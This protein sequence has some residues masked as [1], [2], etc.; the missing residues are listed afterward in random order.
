MPGL[1]YFTEFPDN[2]KYTTLYLTQSDFSVPE[3]V[4]LSIRQRLR[5]MPPLKPLDH[6]EV[7][8]EGEDAETQEMR[9]PSKRL[10]Q[11]CEARSMAI[12]THL[13]LS[14]LQAP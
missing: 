9:E 5:K 1:R 8:K 2:W 11:G 4:C 6:S 13:C 14:E 12:F 3:S 10:R 7:H